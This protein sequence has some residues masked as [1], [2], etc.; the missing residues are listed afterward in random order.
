M[1][2]P[3]VLTQEC[4]EE[5]IRMCV[6]MFYKQKCHM[7]IICSKN[8]RYFFKK[9]VKKE[10]NIIGSEGREGGHPGPKYIIQK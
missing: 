2:I 1:I 9:V 5:Q 3:T 7:V 6:E 8:N 10:T 4:S